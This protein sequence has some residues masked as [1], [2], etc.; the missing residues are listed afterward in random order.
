MD[1]GRGHERGLS[2]STFNK[3]IY[4]PKDDCRRTCGVD[5]VEVFIPASVQIN[6]FLDDR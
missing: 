4:D 3:R 2:C 5:D 6:T 1:P